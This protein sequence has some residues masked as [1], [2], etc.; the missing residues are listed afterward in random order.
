MW[1]QQPEWHSVERQGPTVS[2]N[3]IRPHP[4]SDSAAVAEGYS[5]H[6]V[7]GRSLVWF[8]CS[9]CW[10]VL[11]QDTEPQTAPDVLVG[12]LHGSHHQPRMYIWIILK[13]IGQK[14]LLNV[15]SITPSD[16]PQYAWE[17]NKYTKKKK[18]KST[19]LET[20][21]KNVLHPH[22]KLMGSIRWSLISVHPEG[23]M[24]DCTRFH[25][26]PSRDCRDISVRLTDQ[27]TDQKKTS[28]CRATWKNGNQCCAQVDPGRQQRANWRSFLVERACKAGREYTGDVQ[29]WNN[30]LPSSVVKFTTACCKRNKWNERGVI[31]KIGIFRKYGRVCDRALRRST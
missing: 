24:N 12:T 29:G 25:G 2:F 8:P 21:R 6:L 14:C 17:I 9:A 11:G 20:V 5:Q 27:L 18:S 23:H 4:I 30:F 1:Q 28:I 22:Q 19:M 7:M 31:W 13:L 16:T 3:S 15:N 26:D 10:S